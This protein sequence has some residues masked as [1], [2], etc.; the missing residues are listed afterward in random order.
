MVRDNPL[1]YLNADVGNCVKAAVVKRPC[2]RPGVR[3]REKLLAFLEATRAGE[4]M[5][6]TP[7]FDRR[8]R[9]RGYEILAEQGGIAS[10][11][12]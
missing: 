9:L 11:S 2:R 8:A 12:P 4:I 10:A 1:V 7:I 6:N 5:V 3:V